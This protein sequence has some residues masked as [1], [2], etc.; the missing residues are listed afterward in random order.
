MIVKQISVFLENKPGQLLDVVNI[1][2]QNKI[3]M[4]ALSVAEAQEYGVM[5]A[6]VDKP[7]ETEKILRAQNWIC[8]LTEVLAVT[9]PDTPGSLS[10]LLTV[11]ADN[12]ISL[13]YSY[14]FLAPQA[15]S[16]CIV[17]RVDDN[18]FAQKLLRDAGID[19]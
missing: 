11:L 17:L 3:D 7:E 19:C 10:M 15:G 2:A 13:A 14:A 9:V 5:R 6:I 16:A 12:G 1:L 18:A 8:S 4:R